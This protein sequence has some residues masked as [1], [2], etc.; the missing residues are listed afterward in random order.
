MMLYR[1]FA[2]QEEIDKG[3]PVSTSLENALARLS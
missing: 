2:T 1:Q 3:G